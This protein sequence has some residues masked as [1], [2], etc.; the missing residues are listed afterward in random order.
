[1]ANGFDQLLVNMQ[2]M[3]FFQ[4]LFPFLLSLAII[5][6]VMK[7]TL[8]DR[9]PK[10]AMG[11]IALVISFFV[12]LYSSWNSMIVNF[13]ANISGTWLIVASGILFVLILLGLTGF[14][15]SELFE[16]T[17]A[18]WIAVIVVV[19]IGILIFMGA[20]GGMFLNLPLSSD[21]WTIIFFVAILAIVVFWFG[22][23]GGEEKQP[24]QPKTQ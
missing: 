9:L 20:G 24:K 23:E 21:F 6:G 3:G 17:K 18:K 7:F 2:N 10:S 19:F 22:Q 8:Q 11:V 1:M 15:T 4:F 16:N 12:M 14:K 13:F 5:Y